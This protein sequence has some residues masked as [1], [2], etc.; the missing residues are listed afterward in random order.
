MTTG[1]SSDGSARGL[2]DVFSLL[3]QGTS[4]RTDHA[5]LCTVLPGGCHSFGIGGDRKGGKETGRGGK[6]TNLWEL[7]V[8]SNQSLSENQPGFLTK[9]KSFFLGNLY[10]SYL[11]SPITHPYCW[12]NGNSPIS[13][14]HSS[15][16]FFSFFQLLVIC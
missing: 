3:A 8:L 13:P 7:L 4:A 15:F 2:S 5:P 16:F 10:S 14:Y 1:S 6:K 11:L 12:R 9:P